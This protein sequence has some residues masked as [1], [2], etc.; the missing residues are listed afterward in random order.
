MAGHSHWAGIKHKKGRQDKLRSKIFSKISKEITVAAKQGSKDPET[1]RH[2]DKTQIQRDSDPSR[3]KKRFS[4]EPP[5]P[6]VH[7]R[8]FSFDLGWSGNVPSDSF[9]P[10]NDFLG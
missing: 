4:S 1:F 10:Q 3:A 5:L 9:V 6:S 8:D 2:P 7:L